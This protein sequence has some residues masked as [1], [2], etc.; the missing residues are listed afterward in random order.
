[1][2]FLQTERNESHSDASNAG[3]PHRIEPKA[4]NLKT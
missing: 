2:N 4:A 3:S 1:M